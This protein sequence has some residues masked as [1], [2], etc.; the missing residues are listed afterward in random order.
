MKLPL[1]PAE[2]VPQKTVE[3]VAGFPM[4]GFVVLLA[5]HKVGVLGAL[6]LDILV[7]PLVS[8]ALVLL[9]VAKLEESLLQWTAQEE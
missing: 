4:S 6:A 5:V 3:K 9:P 8:S 1:V 2:P 7:V